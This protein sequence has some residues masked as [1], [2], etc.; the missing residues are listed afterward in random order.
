M[1]AVGTEQQR[2]AIRRCIRHEALP[3]M[4]VAPTLFSTMKGC[5][6]AACSSACLGEDRGPGCK[7]ENSQNDAKHVSAPCAS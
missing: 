7:P 1:A 4:P 5:P 3:T 2:V 6:K